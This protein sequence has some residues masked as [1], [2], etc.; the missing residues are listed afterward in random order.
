MLFV[1]ILNVLILNCI[2]LNQVYAQLDKDY[3][4]HV[5]YSQRLLFRT[6]L[7]LNKVN[8]NND[9][10]SNEYAKIFPEYGEYYWIGLNKIDTI[11][12][13]G[14][15]TYEYIV[16]ERCYSKSDSIANAIQKSDPELHFSDGVFKECQCCN[17]TGNPF[18]DR[19]IGVGDDCINTK[20]IILVDTSNCVKTPLVYFLSGNCVFI[21]NIE[22]KYFNFNE[23]NEDN[24]NLI[25]TL[26]LWNSNIYKSGSRI[27]RI[28]KLR[29]RK[30]RI[31]FNDT[32]GTRILKIKR[33]F[34]FVLK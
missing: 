13:N 27:K 7:Y 3:I 33:S 18:K 17:L 31:F 8:L 10:K 30:Y 28:E 21:D 12:I 29:K 16:F 24:I 14:F 23:L 22:K 32:D 1:P 11:K 2:A 20:G 19:I 6:N 9:R 34:L 25:L 26:K 15:V 5:I 4:E